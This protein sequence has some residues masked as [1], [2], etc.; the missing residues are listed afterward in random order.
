MVL[1]MNFT[2]ILLK[3]ITVWL[4]YILYYWLYILHP[5]YRFD[6]VSSEYCL[7][8]RVKNK[9]LIKIYL[10]K[11]EPKLIFCAV[12]AIVYFMIGFIYT[13]LCIVNYYLNFIFFDIKYTLYFSFGIGVVIPFLYNIFLDIFRRDK[14]YK[15][16]NK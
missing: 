3:T 13:A 5:E 14:L 6:T 9:I 11:T 8:H 1:G 10:K 7:R 2:N 15:K 4:F 12:Y 16:N